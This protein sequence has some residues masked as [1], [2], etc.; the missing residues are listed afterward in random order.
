MVS[1]LCTLRSR[2]LATGGAPGWAGLLAQSQEPQ[3][4]QQQQQ[5]QLQQQQQ[6]QQDFEERDEL[7]GQP[8]PQLT[9]RELLAQLRRGAAAFPCSTTC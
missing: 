4:H 3:L 2:V 1:D 7:R 9:E 8:P 6:Q 5:Q